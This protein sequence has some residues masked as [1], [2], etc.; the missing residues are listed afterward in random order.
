MVDDCSNHGYVSR[1]SIRYVNYFCKDV[2]FS[3]C[4]SNFSDDFDL[5]IVDFDLSLPVEDPGDSH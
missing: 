1:K 2:S 3:P 5:F 4:F